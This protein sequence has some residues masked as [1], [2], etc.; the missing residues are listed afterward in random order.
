[1]GWCYGERVDVDAVSRVD[2]VF[3]EV[4]FRHCAGVYME[5]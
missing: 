2:C 5:M 1:M 4:L 3:G